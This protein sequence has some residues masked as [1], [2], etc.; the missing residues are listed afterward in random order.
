MSTLR[1][2]NHVA[3]FFFRAQ[4]ADSP[5]GKTLLELVETGKLAAEQV[6][7]TTDDD[8][9]EWLK[10]NPADVTLSVPDV[11]S[12]VVDGVLTDAQLNY[13]QAVVVEH[14]ETKQQAETS[15]CTGKVIDWAELF[16]AAFVT[17]AVQVK[18]TADMLKAAKAAVQSALSGELDGQVY[19]KPAG[20][21]AVAGLFDNRASMASCLKYKPDVLT[22][23]QGA[24]AQAAEVLAGAEQLEAHSAAIDLILTNIQN[25]LA[26]KTTELSADDI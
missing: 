24:I 9:V 15:A 20:I 1:T 19:A 6:V 13:L 22:R 26:P 11:R 25:A 23:L 21:A 4:K 10:R 2:L 8:K 16:S 12:I 7:A 3:R 18:V 17:K 5:A 14:I